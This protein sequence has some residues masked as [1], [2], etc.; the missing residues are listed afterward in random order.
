MLPIWKGRGWIAPIIFI[1][2]FVDVQLV[3]DY[4]MGE[5][6]YSDNRWVK[7]ISLT[8]VALGVG[9]IGYSLNRRDRIVHVNSETG[10]KS[11]SSAHT[12]LFL[13]IE[14]WAIIVPCFFL[15]VDYFNAEQESK[16]LAYLQKPKVNDVYGV[17]FSKIFKNE[18][19]V[20]KYGT[21][22]V[23][24]VNL[25]VVEVQSSTHAY[26]GKSGVRKDL[27]NGKALEAFYYT[28]VMTPFNVRE[29]LKFYENGAIFSVRRETP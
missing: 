7:L 5:G 12:L 10:K 17:D 20:Y 8:V 1:A 23:V 26:N 28:D 6:F 18:D 11:L 16:T 15:A 13:P 4:F 21:M 19:P 22:V 24:A 14:V 29:L 25:N 3:V 27:H 2:F 9:V